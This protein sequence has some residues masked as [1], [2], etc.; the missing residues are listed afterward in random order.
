MPRRKT[1]TMLAVLAIA[2]L[3]SLSVSACG[4]LVPAPTATPTAIPPL[5]LEALKNA[6]YQSEFPAS[7]KAK[8]TDGK[9]EEEI[10][11]GA[12]SK[13]IIV[14]YPDMYAFGDLNGDGVD[15]AAVVLATSGGGSG[16]FISL[17][18][19]IND[20]GTPKHIASASLGDRARIKSI[21]IQSGEIAVNMVQQAP[22]DPMCCPTMEVTQTYRLQGDQLVST[23][24]VPP[25][26]TTV[27]LTPTT[28]IEML[29]PPT[30]A[31]IMAQG[32]EL[33]FEICGEST[34]WTRPT[35]KEQN[36]K[37]SSGR[38]ADGNEEVIKYP[39]IHN[40]FVVYGHA[41]GEYDI[42]N[43]SGLWTLSGDVRAKCFEPEPHDDILKL[44]TAEVWTLLYRVISIKRLDTH[45]VV[46]VEPME[47]GVQFVQF[48]RPERQL[49]LTLHFVA[50]DGQE[51]EGIVEAESPYW[52]Y[53]QL[54]PTPQ[55]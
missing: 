29:H 18:A 54:I 51:V 2:L 48:A 39:W 47:K 46:L 44:K 19:V 12:A 24:P 49:P 20:K 31:K 15:D 6:E 36:A 26:A 27:A 50:K 32:E 52:P 53:P 11:P 38:Y 3:V 1:S 55:P 16:T 43:L 37:W 30:V 22:G 9:Y 7:K 13:L 10:V 17:E 40:F 8:L 45:Y 34:T 28:S 41:S 21:A 25:T 4:P 23:K 5:T 33:S 14:V 42:I 35:E